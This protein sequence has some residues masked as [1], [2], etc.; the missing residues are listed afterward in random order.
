MS[1]KQR[2]PR[3]NGALARARTARHTRTNRHNARRRAARSSASEQLLDSIVNSSCGWHFIYEGTMPRREEARCVLDDT[4]SPRAPRLVYADEKRERKKE[5]VR[6]TSSTLSS[7]SFSFSS[8]FFSFSFSLVP[9]GRSSRDNWLV[10]SFISTLR[11]VNH[12][13]WPR[14]ISFFFYRKTIEL[15]FLR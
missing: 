6:T 10:N 3:V 1:G 5:L 15:L 14:E 7:F 13:R 12:Q 2:E 9:H 11:R 8:F 4:T